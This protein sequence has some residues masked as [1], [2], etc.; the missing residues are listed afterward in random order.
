MVWCILCSKNAISEAS[1]VHSQVARTKVL[2]ILDLIQEGYVPEVVTVESEEDY[3]ER[4]CFIPLFAVCCVIVEF[5]HGFRSIDPFIRSI[6]SLTCD[7]K[8][9][10]G[11]YTTT[12][13][14][15]L[16]R[17]SQQWSS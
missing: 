1:K 9:L 13:V 2:E 11:W 8:A 10:G 15:F 12:S 17:K 4:L 16:A 14:H 3:Q 7:W 6:H 5:G